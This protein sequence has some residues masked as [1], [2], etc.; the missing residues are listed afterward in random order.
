MANGHGGA[1]PGAGRKKASTKEAQ[2]CRRDII[3]DV[4]TPEET[5]A[6]AEAIL[7]RIKT[8][9][10]PK[11][12]GSIAPF[13]FGKEPDEVDVKISGGVH[14]FLPERKAPS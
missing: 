5:R 9:G 8:T 12:F 7:L 4:F 3:L 2:Q 11:A 6:A 1:R 13:I 14:I 10:D